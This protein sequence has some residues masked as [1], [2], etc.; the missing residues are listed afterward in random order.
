MCYAHVMHVQCT[1]WR[2][3]LLT[4][5]IKNSSKPVEPMATSTFTP[6]TA[7]SQTM[8]SA[9]R[10][11]Q[12]ALEEAWR[13]KW[14]AERP[15]LESMY[16]ECHKSKEKKEHAKATETFFASLHGG[17]SHVAGL[18]KKEC[19]DDFMSRTRITH[20]EA[21]FAQFQSQEATTMGSQQQSSEENCAS[22]LKLRVFKNLA[23]S[24]ARNDAF[25][26]LVGRVP[27]NRRERRAIQFETKGLRITPRG[28][29][30][31]RATGRTMR[32]ERELKTVRERL[33]KR[34]QREL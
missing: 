13:K 29:S 18:M 28:M 31:R 27:T 5:I 19:K 12:Q 2:R 20:Q 21:F 9:L 10:Q 15:I 14:A 30:N 4:R 34:L 24:K 8:S 11:T 6:P 7:Q 25:R 32:Q 26:R 22:K 23:A 17:N 16:D 1:C 33:R 3:A